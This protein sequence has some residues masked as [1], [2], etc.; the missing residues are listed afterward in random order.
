MTIIDICAFGDFDSLYSD[1]L[2]ITENDVDI[3]KLN[4]E[5]V[6]KMED[7]SLHR[8]I[9]LEEGDY[10]LKIAYDKPYSD[11]VGEDTVLFKDYDIICQSQALRFSTDE[12]KSYLKENGFEPLKSITTT[13]NSD[14]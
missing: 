2:M 4:K 8:Y 3:N 13:I 10:Y 6:K 11:N 5:F 9:I 14:M 7:N 12:Y 1:G